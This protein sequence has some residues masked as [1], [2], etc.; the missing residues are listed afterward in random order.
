MPFSTDQP[1][2]EMRG[3]LALVAQHAR[4]VAE[5]CDLLEAIADDLPR[6]PKPIWSEVR[7]LCGATIQ[8]HYDE[9]LRALVPVL[10]R[11]TRGDADCEDMLNRMRLDYVDGQVR[12]PELE[13]LLNDASRVNGPGLGANALGFALRSFFETIRRQTDWEMDVLLPMARRRLTPSDLAEVKSALDSLDTWD[14]PKLPNVSA[15]GKA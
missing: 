7:R 2:G 1:A 8:Q 14:A 5:L 10:M 11:R 13:E 3:P 4:R 15:V 6:Q 9:V 12:L